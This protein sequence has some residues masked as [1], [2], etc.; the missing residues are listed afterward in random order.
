MKISRSDLYKIIIEEYVKGEDIEE[1]QAAQD[2][3][4]QIL[5]DEEYE[6]RQAL[7]NRGARGGDTKPM[8]KPHQA[9]DTMPFDTGEEPEPESLEDRI[10]DMVKGMSP[11]EVSDLFQAVFSKIPGIE[12]GE[13]EEEPGTLYTPGAEGRPQMGFRL[14]ELKQ[15]IREVLAENVWAFN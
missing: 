15:M 14:E 1:S 5:G 6:R 4:R 3:L 13:P 11:E 2:L 10:A 12:M 8:E 9:A 7:K